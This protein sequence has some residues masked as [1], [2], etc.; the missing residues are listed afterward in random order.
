MDTRSSFLAILLALT[1][2]GC[3]FDEPLLPGPP[4]AL[5]R[6]LLGTWRCVAP[7]ARE[8]ARL[9]VATTPEGWYR[10]EI[11]SEDEE[12]TAWH[13]YAVDFEKTRLL[14]VQWVGDDQR[15]T[16]TVARYTLFKPTLLNLE[17]M[18]DEPFEVATSRQARLSILKNAP[19][20]FLDYC[21]C[22]RIEDSAR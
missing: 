17:R 20:L 10:A 1:A 8:T 22:V 2:A 12:P 19:G 16:W 21:T 4:L 11:R 7:D 13:A 9:T 5:E 6:Q 15:K 14:N 18:K 3:L